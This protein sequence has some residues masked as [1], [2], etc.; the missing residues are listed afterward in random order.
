MNFAKTFSSFLKLLGVD[1]KKYIGL[2]LKDSSGNNYTL[3]QMDSEKFKSFE[4]ANF[5]ARENEIVK[6]TGDM[7]T[8]CSIGIFEKFIAKRTGKSYTLGKDYKN[9][10]QGG[11]FERFEIAKDIYCLI[12]D[13]GSEIMKLTDT[14]PVYIEDGAPD[15]FFVGFVNKKTYKK[16]LKL[17]EKLN[18]HTFYIM[19]GINNGGLYKNTYKSCIVDGKT[20]VKN[21]YNSERNNSLIEQLKAN[22][23]KVDFDISPEQESVFLPKA[24]NLYDEIKVYGLENLNKSEPQKNIE[25]SLTQIFAI[26]LCKNLVSPEKLKDLEIS[27]GY[28]FHLFS[29]KADTLT[30]PELISQILLASNDE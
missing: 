15:D 6:L 2:S 24:K 1:I 8:I 10:I 30:T 13:I 4:W 19:G 5:L 22:Q 28:F 17:A 12:R 7:D 16:Y 11:D 3:S 20:I 18:V 23:A 27:G 21:F 25:N 9:D 26:L 29:D 14:Y